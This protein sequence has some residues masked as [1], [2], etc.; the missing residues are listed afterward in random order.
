MRCAYVSVEKHMHHQ[1]ICYCTTKYV[2]SQL[3]MTSS[4]VMRWVAETFVAETY[5]RITWS[6]TGHIHVR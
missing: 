4:Y 2:T 6:I 5:L 3:Q 1:D